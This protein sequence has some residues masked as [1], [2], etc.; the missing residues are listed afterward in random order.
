MGDQVCE[1]EEI[2]DAAEEQRK[3]IEMDQRDPSCVHASDDLYH[4]C[5]EH[6]LRRSPAEEP[7]NDDRPV[8]VLAQNGHKNAE[9]G[10]RRVKRKDGSGG[11]P[12]Y[13][14][15]Q[16][17]SNK[18]GKTVDPKCKNASNPY[19][20][21]TNYCVTKM[22]NE[23]KRDSTPKSPLSFL[24]RHSSFS[25]SSGRSNKTVGEN[26]KVDPKCKNASNPYHECT[27]RCFNNRAG[28]APALQVQ[29][30]SNEEVKYNKVDPKCP[31]ASNLYHECNDLCLTKLKLNGGP[32]RE[33]GPKS[34][35][36]FLSRLSSSSSTGSSGKH[37]EN[38]K[39][40]SRC[41][42]ASNPY[43]ECN[44]ICFQK[45]H[46]SNPSTPDLS[47]GRNSKENGE[48]RE[49]NPSC[50]NASNPYHKCTDKCF[51]KIQR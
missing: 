48:R 3:V 7:T 15:L 44:D 33:E 6:C 12:L 23:I 36:S 20:I 9:Q 16:D 35:F 27:D 5:S 43:H 32:K 37:G 19:H 50:L 10:K 11:L 28:S 30:G 47:M 29:Y 22:N 46:V 31:N 38:N 24:S 39:V 17:G 34:P 49:V 2:Q 42:N 26:K 21:C 25:S 18:E 4:R 41:K 45:L 51:D 14:F 13:V 1:I 40:D 8:T